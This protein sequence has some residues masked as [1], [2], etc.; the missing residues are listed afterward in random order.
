MC[1][2]VCVFSSYI[3]VSHILSNDLLSLTV[4]DATFEHTGIIYL[5]SREN[6]FLGGDFEFIDRRRDHLAGENGGMAG[7]KTPQRLKGS[8]AVAEKGREQERDSYKVWVEPK[9]GRLLLFTSGA[10]NTHRVRKVRALPGGPLQRRM[11]DEAD[12]TIYQER[13]GMRYAWVL[14]T[15][16]DEKAAANA[17]KARAGTLRDKMNT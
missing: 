1:A 16:C 14:A 6:N 3:S 4:I 7:D 12:N 9:Q 8:G 10:E 13:P 15:T 17:N 5:S 11:H 2:S